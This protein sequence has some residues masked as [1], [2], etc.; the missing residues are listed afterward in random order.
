[1]DGWLF[2]FPSRQWYPKKSYLSLHTPPYVTRNPQTSSITCLSKR[3]ISPKMLWIGTWH[4]LTSKQP[5]I[6]DRNTEQLGQLSYPSNITSQE[7]EEIILVKC[8]SLTRIKLT[9]QTNN[10]TKSTLTYIW[11]N[12]HSCQIFTPTYTQSIA[13][14]MHGLPRP[15]KRPF[16]GGKSSAG[17][18][19]YSRFKITLLS[20]QRN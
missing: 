4:S 20:H 2:S 18:I 10:L 19:T 1:M 17:P 15:V 12:H 9:V 16:Q 3:K 6:Q 14:G 5:C 11:T 13:T 7:E 8:Y